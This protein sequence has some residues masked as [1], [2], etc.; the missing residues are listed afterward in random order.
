MP[1]ATHPR[2]LGLTCASGDPCGT[3][4]ARAGVGCAWGARGRELSRLGSADPERA[5]RQLHPLQGRNSRC[6][7]GNRE[8]SRL[9]DGCALNLRGLR[10]KAEASEAD[11]GARSG[12]AQKVALAAWRGSPLPQQSGQG[13][14]AVGRELARGDPA[15]TGG[16]SLFGPLGPRAQACPAARSASPESACNQRQLLQNTTVETP[17]RTRAPA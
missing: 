12:C 17:N 16:A 3:G 6:A 8:L 14:C 2:A 9:H 5:A 1:R 11:A 7:G 4:G 15:P 13:H 10:E